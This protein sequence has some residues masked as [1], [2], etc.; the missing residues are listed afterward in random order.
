[1]R[2]PEA[3]GAEV[4]VAGTQGFC[5]S[6]IAHLLLAALAEASLLIAS[7]DAPAAARAEVERTL[8]ALLDGLRV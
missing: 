4:S 6:H 5:S 1:V 2:G 7:A 3:L 8:L